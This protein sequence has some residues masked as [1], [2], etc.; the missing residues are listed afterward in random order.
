MYI[1]IV[2]QSFH[3]QR[4]G[5]IMSG[6]EFYMVQ[7]ASEFLLWSDKASRQIGMSS[8]NLSLFFQPLSGLRT[9]AQLCGPSSPL[10]FQQ[11]PRNRRRAPKKKRF[12]LRGR[13]RRASQAGQPRLFPPRT[14]TGPRSRLPVLGFCLKE[15]S[16][17]RLVTPG[18]TWCPSTFS[19]S[20]NLIVPTWSRFV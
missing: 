1:N 4:V 8:A 7:A 14:A 10:W 5:V 17:T 16:S 19:P 18:T 3:E 12:Q 20:C 2:C 6:Q 13:E 11:M 15:T 9:V